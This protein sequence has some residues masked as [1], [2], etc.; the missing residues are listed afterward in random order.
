MISVHRGPHT[1]GVR[2][3]V[4]TS[5]PPLGL[6]AHKLVVHPSA[7]YTDRQ[8]VKHVIL[9]LTSTVFTDVIGMVPDFNFKIMGSP[10]SIKV[11][12]DLTHDVTHFELKFIWDRAPL[13]WKKPVFPLMNSVVPPVVDHAKR[14]AVQEITSKSPFNVFNIVAIVAVL[15]IGYFLYKKFND[16][17]QKGAIKF[18][19][20]V[21][22][23]TASPKIPESP[24]IV[25][26]KPEVIPEPGVKD[27]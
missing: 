8:V 25:D 9:S 23:A 12:P 15:V 13:G 5:R 19:S 21:P 22:A 18:P 2:L 24:I 27:E 20:I 26:A 17:F 16:K 6:V 3:A 10:T 14:A 7:I 1:R 4:I 11:G